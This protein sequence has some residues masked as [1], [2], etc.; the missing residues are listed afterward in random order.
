[1]LN[2]LSYVAK[3]LWN[4][5]LNKLDVSTSC[6]VMFQDFFVENIESMHFF[7]IFSKKFSKAFKILT[8]VF[9]FSTFNRRMFIS[10]TLTTDEDAEHEIVTKNHR[11]IITEVGVDFAI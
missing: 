3:S 9:G 2:R 11:I 10:G 6:F 1:M 4:L 7:Y 5:N 8:V